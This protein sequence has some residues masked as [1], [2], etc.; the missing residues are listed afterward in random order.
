MSFPYESVF[1]FE[2]HLTNVTGQGAS[3]LAVSLLDEMENTQAA[4]IVKLYLPD[5]AWV[6]ESRLMEIQAER[7]VHRRILPNS[8]SRFVELF[9][10]SGCSPIKPLLVLGDVPIRAKVPQVVFVQTPHL[11]YDIKGLGFLGW[12]KNRL[13]RV[14]MVRNLKFVSAIIVQTEAMKES[15]CAKFDIPPK[16]VFIIPQPPPGMIFSRIDTPWSFSVG[17]ACEGLKL[18]YPAAGYKHKNHSILY[19]CVEGDWPV[20]QFSITD[21]RKLDLDRL[22]AWVRFIGAVHPA[23]IVDRYLEHDALVFL[24]TAESYGFPLVEAMLLG[25]PII[26]ADLPFARELCGATAI[27]FDPS[28]AT[29]LRDA[30]YELDM[31]LHDG[32]RPDWSSQIMKL[33]SSWDDVAHQFISVVR[34]AAKIQ[35]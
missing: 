6:Y 14:A 19:D 34:E 12:L 7:V 11:S 17:H 33:P 30:V 16:N 18:F 1:E 2:I 26:C 5:A 27:Y 10:F 28:S 8:L 31:R 9:I 25:L 15:L 21:N 13:L 24:S 32:W 22:P 4:K 35:G 29:S 23:D 3:L 20:A